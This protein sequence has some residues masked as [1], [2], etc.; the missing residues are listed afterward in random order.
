VVK[1]VVAVT[2]SEGFVGR[3]VVDSLTRSPGVEVVRIVR[4]GSRAEPKAGCRIVTADVL[5]DSREH[6]LERAPADIL[7]HLAW[8]GLNDFRSDEHRDQVTA[9]VRFLDRSVDAG[10]KRVVC[11]GT[12]L[13]YGLVEGEVDE[14][15]PAQPTIAYA[16]AKNELHKKLLEIMQHKA[17]SLLWARIFYPFGP[18]Q[19]SKSLW[20]SL[21]DAIDRADRTFPMSPGMQMR[22]YLPVE[23]VGAI[24]AQLACA[25]AEGVLNVCSG[26]PVVLRQLVAD[27]TQDRGSEIALEPG[28]YGYPDYEPMEFWGSRRRLNEALAATKRCD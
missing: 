25:D 12:C 18:G 10:V 24:L 23:D 5:A 21:Q 28:V 17:A 1:T 20:T 19:H 9:H 2:G 4:P 3:H 26:E 27:W 8:R 11:A 22:D 14:E 15:S 16:Q 13:E 7:V 6:P